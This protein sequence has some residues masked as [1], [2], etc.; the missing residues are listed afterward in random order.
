MWFW[1]FKRG[2]LYVLQLWHATAHM[3]RK[4][5][6]QVKKDQCRFFSYLGLDGFLF[7]YGV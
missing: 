7:A 3:T 6:K 1:R 2:A 5:P 4:K